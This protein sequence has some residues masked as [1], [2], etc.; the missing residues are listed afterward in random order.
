M[1]IYSTELIY[2]EYI[3]YVKLNYRVITESSPTP[4]VVKE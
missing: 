4:I 1:L 2:V 3:C